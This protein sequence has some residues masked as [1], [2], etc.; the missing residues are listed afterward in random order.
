M[1]T[2]RPLIAV[3][4]TNSRVHARGRVRALRRPPAVSP[5]ARP[6]ARASDVRNAVDAAM[7]TELLAGADGCIT[8]WGSPPI[9]ADLLGAAPNLRIIA[10][11]AG[12][13]RPYLTAAV[14]ERDIAVVSA[15]GAIAEEVAQYTAALIV[16]GR[17][18]LMELAPQTAQGKWRDVQLHRPSSDVRGITVGIIGAGEVGRRVL[19]LLGHFQVRLLLADPFVS[20]DQAA[21][22]GAEKCE[23]EALFAESDVVSV[24]APNNDQTRHMVNAERAGAAARRRDFHQHLAR[25]VGRPGGAGRRAA[26]APHLGVHRRHRPGTAAARLIAVRLSAPDPV[27]ARRRLDQTARAVSSC[28]GCSTKSRGCS[29]ASR[30]AT[31]RSGRWWR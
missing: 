6:A 3:L 7:A 27:A 20:A 16:I 19:A 9:S 13:L 17:R 26:P 8:C 14:W 10:H 4:N 23:L 18:S 22:L 12:T 15:A 29:P 21:A 31:R 25:P 24:H 28:A 30:C 11:A 5:P 2:E 1:A